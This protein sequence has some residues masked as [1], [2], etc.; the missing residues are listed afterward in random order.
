M[1]VR[2]STQ[3]SAPG[4]GLQETSGDIDESNRGS[5]GDQTSMVMNHDADGKRVQTAIEDRDRSGYTVL[6]K[7]DKTVEKTEQSN[8]NEREAP[9]S[10]TLMRTSR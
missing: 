9:T 1:F 5:H 6:L 4:Q 8:V 3:L 7:S 2:D 10:R